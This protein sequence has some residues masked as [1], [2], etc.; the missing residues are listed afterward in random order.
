MHKS[1]LNRESRECVVS[2]SSLTF[3]LEKQHSIVDRD[4]DTEARLPGFES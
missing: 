4:K 1:A 3:T 2:K